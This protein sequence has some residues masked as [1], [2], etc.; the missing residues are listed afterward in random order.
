MRHFCPCAV[1]LLLL[2]WM[3]TTSSSAARVLHCTEAAL[4]SLRGCRPFQKSLTAHRAERV[5][6]RSP[7]GVEVPISL[8]FRKDLIR[9]G[10]PGSPLLLEG[11][12]AY[13]IAIDPF[14]DSDRLSILDMYAKLLPLVAGATAEL[15]NTEIKVHTQP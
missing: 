11:Y 15:C 8:V 12:G 3:N 7:D 1:Y 9:Y 2:K 14:F 10:G 13:G 6:S 5:W 4:F